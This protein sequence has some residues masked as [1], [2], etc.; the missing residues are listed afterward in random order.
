[1]A[2]K[3][4]IFQNFENLSIFKFA[5]FFRLS[6]GNQFYYCLQVDYICTQ[7]YDIEIVSIWF[8]L[9]VMSIFETLVKHNISFYKY[10]VFS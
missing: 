6:K 10:P 7:V 3:I 9:D 1:M 2:R 8:R 4:G 5:Y